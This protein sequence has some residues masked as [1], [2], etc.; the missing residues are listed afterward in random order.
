MA[1]WRL[2]NYKI[3][4]TRAMTIAEVILARHDKPVSVSRTDEIT[5]SSSYEIIRT[6]NRQ[7]H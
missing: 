3:N 5:I 4:A 6:I 7:S 1:T 2:I